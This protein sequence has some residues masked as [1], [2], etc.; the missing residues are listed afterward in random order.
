[1]ILSVFPSNTKILKCTLGQRALSSPVK[2]EGYLSLPMLCIQEDYFCDDMTNLV[3]N[4]RYLDMNN[5]RLF[6]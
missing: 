6:D 1:M 2:R 4:K 5:D 3:L